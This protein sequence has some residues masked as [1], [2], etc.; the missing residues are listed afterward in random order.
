[1]KTPI[2]DMLDNYVAS[3][4]VRM[5]MPGH[6]G[7]INNRDI[8][9]L[10]FSDNLTQP[11]SVIY[12]SQRAYASSIGAKHCHYL[13]GGSSSGIMA[14]VACARGKI[15]T[16]SN[17][18]IS[19]VRSAKLY[20]KQLVYITNRVEQ[21]INMPLCID[22][23]IYALDSDDDIGTILLTSPTYYGMCADLPTIYKL[24][25][26]RDK[27]LFVDSAHGAH[28]GLHRSL[29][30]NA[31]N[32]CDACVQST[33]KTLGALTQT[34]VLLS[35]NTKLSQRL[36]EEL[37]EITT[38]SPSYLLMSSIE[39]SMA[40]ASSNTKLYDML[41]HEVNLLAD[42]IVKLGYGCVVRDDWMRLVIDCK[43]MGYNALAVYKALEAQGVVLEHADNRYLIAIITLYDDGTSLDALYTALRRLDHVGTNVMDNSYILS[44]FAGK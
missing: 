18:H 11:S 38:T 22:D 30:I 31:V 41:Y 32:S 7:H 39:S 15:L 34:A 24:A 21:D 13:V 23:I 44:C 25:K 12:Q 43:P 10:S 9:E 4:A 1:M 5:H 27:I 20:N 14:L 37:V 40:Y 6:K 28:F 42:N 16:E 33:H 26:K 2:N 36:K 17:C 19:V 29:P 35:N 3:Q 8:T